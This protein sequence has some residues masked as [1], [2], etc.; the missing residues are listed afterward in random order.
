MSASQNR[1]QYNT[2][3]QKRCQQFFLYF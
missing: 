3:K 1:K 2:T